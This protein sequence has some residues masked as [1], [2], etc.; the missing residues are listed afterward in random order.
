MRM[1]FCD[2]KAPTVRT[3][4]L[5]IAAEGRFP[6][7]YHS[8][9]RTMCGWSICL[10]RI[11][12]RRGDW[13]RVASWYL[14]ISNLP[15][16]NMFVWEETSF[17]PQELSWRYLVP[18]WATEKIYEMEFFH[19]SFSKWKKPLNHRE[20]FQPPLPYVFLS[21]S[22]ADTSTYLKGQS[23]TL[24][25]LVTEECGS[26]FWLCHISAVCWDPNGI[27]SKLLTI[28]FERFQTRKRTI[29]VRPSYPLAC[30]WI[31][32]LEPWCTH[33]ISSQPHDQL[34]VL[35]LEIVP[36]CAGI[37]KKY[38]MSFTS[39]KWCGNHQ[40]WHDM[41]QPHDQDLLFNLIQWQCRTA[42]LDLGRGR[43]QICHEEGMNDPRHII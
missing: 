30:P 9:S 5:C 34:Y 35:Y 27:D 8:K 24:G 7:S 41:W 20:Y 16:K 11:S 2:S 10:P 39:W 32:I 28:Q 15:M 6:S 13:F 17:E 25:A 26:R 22:F 43:P 12:F 23:S 38:S 31:S 36:P 3:H 37:K 33:D 4:C 1:Q 19:H 40:E 21:I 14:R 42:L 29:A 18:G